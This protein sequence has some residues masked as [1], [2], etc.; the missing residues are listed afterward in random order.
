IALALLALLPF[1]DKPFT[2]DDTLFL[3]QAQHLLIDPLHP[4][5]FDIVWTEDRARLSSIMPSGPVGASLLVRSLRL[6]GVEWAARLAPLA[7]SHLIVLYGVAAL[8][9]LDEDPLRWST[10]RALPW[11]RFL[12]LGGGLL[13]FV[14][15]LRI[16]RDPM[17]AAASV[18]GAVGG[19]TTPVNLHR[20][21]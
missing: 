11:R 21:L 13:V 14:S 6:G 12:I 2:I 10:W 9:L 1:L 17:P 4:T 15:I 16:T 7:R 18:A 8:A 20:H 5:A 19:L 3:R